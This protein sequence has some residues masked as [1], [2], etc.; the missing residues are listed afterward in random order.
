MAAS[1]KNVN[2]N[3]PMGA[4][5]VLKGATFRVW[6]PNALEVYILGDFNNWQKDKKSLLVCN[7]S[8]HWMGFVP[9]AKRGQQY[10]YWVVGNGG[11]GPKRDPYARALSDS[12]DPLEWKCILEKADFPW[13]DS[14]YLTPQFS[15]FVIYQLHVGTFYTPALPTGG[16][17]LDV[18]SKIPYLADLGVTALQLLPIQEFET[19]FSEGYNGVDY[20]SPE[21][22]FAIPDDK[23]LT[24]LVEVNGLLAS[25]GLEPYVAEDL[26]GAPNQLKALVDLCHCFGLAVMFDVVYNHAGGGFDDHSMYF[27]D[28]QANTDDNNNSLYFTSQ[29]FV[30]GLVFD[31]SKPDVQAFLI[32]NAS[33]F[34]EEYHVDGFRYDEVSTIDHLG[35]PDGWN[36]CQ[37]LTSTMKFLKPQAI[38]HAEYWQVNPLIVQN[39]PQGAGFNTT[40]TDGLRNAI[41]DIISN[42]SQPDERPLNMDTLAASMWPQGFDHEW[43]F[44]QGPENHDLVYRGNSLRI[45]SLAD[46]SNSRSWYGRSRSRIATAICL[47]A[48]GIPMLFMG[49]EF[50]EAQQWADDIK[51]YP[52]LL[53]NWQGLSAGDKQMQDHLRF[54][55]DLV[56][57]RWQYPALRD[58]GFSVI[59][60]NDDNRVCAFHR[61]VEGEG[62]DIMV[63][64]HLSTFDRY[65]YRIGFPWGGIWRE[66]FN[67][68]VYE[69]W[70]NPNVRGN[71]G[72]ITSD[73]QFYDGLNF[74]AA[75]T[76]PAN[77]ILV[78]A[79]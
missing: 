47:T 77:G 74:S 62:M 19:T 79:R 27:F 68:D 72:Q 58:G 78:F 54:T 63:I 26:Q 40:L 45:A 13:H 30:G 17:F 67:S 15:D 24:Y 3:T 28:R 11:S 36:F 48:P 66:V 55:G 39:I 51:D 61:W 70:V 10:W 29:G 56:K 46:P 71:G 73:E 16:T 23:L 22:S 5:L 9:T 75:L 4:N 59:H 64:I 12:E 34:I 35:Q 6:A 20:F 33:F 76:L 37:N 43:Q 69:D 50:L 32:N 41:R 25:K 1:Q 57:L 21:M 38:N 53:L 52:E 14:G 42:A 18:V 2:D 44:V 65:A 49:Q 60:T 8:G 7:S 31:Y